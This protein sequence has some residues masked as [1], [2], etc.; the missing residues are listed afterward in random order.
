MKKK[1]AA[2]PNANRPF[3]DTFAWLVVA[4]QVLGPVLLALV[5]IITLVYALIHLLFL[6]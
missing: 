4:F 1:R 5:V 6:H 3:G 2:K